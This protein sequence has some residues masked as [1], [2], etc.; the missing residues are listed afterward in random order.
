MSIFFLRTGGEFRPQSELATVTTIGISALIGAAVGL[1]WSVFILIPTIIL[2]AI[3]AAVIQVARGDHAGSAALV[4]A[5]VVIALQIGY[6][7]GS[8]ARTAV[9]RLQGRTNAA[10]D[11][12]ENMEVVGSDGQHVG[13]VDHKEAAN[14]IVL[15]GD[16]PKAGGMPHIISVDWVDFVDRKVH[17]NKPA[18]EA[19]LEWQA[20][21]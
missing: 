9:E 3:C 12:E 5:L 11:I 6:L 14:Q 4:I 17:L 21:A 15:T 10:L 18:K 7:V 2:A 8:I 19:V 13:M 1:R 20:A 16:D